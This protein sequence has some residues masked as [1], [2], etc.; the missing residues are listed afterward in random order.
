MSLTLKELIKKQMFVWDHYSKQGTTPW[1][2][3]IAIQDMAYQ[4]GSLTK[5][6]LQLKNYRYRDGADDKTIL[7]KMSD[8]LADILAETLFVA[9]ELGIDLD[10]AFNDMLDNDI[11]KIAERN[12]SVKIDLKETV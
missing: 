8:E 2:A 6:N 5:L 1:T 9:T 3:D 12:P 10:K 7:A 11:R 4:I